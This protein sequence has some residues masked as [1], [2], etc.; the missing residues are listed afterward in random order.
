MRQV[1]APRMMLADQTE[2]AAPDDSPEVETASNP[3][4]GSLKSLVGSR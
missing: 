2:T 1:A 4:P 3:D